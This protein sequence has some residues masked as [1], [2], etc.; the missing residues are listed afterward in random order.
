MEK[1]NAERKSE[2][3][4]IVQPT[5]SSTLGVYNSHPLLATYVL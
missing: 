2:V 5:T 1:K 4:R 3:S